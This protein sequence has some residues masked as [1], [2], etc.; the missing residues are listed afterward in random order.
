MSMILN[1]ILLSSTNYINNHITLNQEYEQESNVYKK[2]HLKY[3]IK[4]V[5][6]AFPKCGNVN[7]TRDIMNFGQISILFNNTKKVETEH[8]VLHI[9]G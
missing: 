4:N 2:I 8:E 9:S 1:I 6:L 7:V 5:Y 3:C